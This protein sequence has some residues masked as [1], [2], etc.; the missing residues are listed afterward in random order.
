[1]KLIV[2]EKKMEIEIKEEST[3]YLEDRKIILEKGEK[4]K[5]K[6]KKDDIEDSDTMKKAKSDNKTPEKDEPLDTFSL[7]AE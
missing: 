4:F 3:I 2:K 1:M 7:S 6:K 5:I